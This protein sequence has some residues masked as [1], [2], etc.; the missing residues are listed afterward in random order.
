MCGTTREVELAPLVL[1]GDPLDAIGG[2]ALVGYARV[3]TDGQHL[4]R[5]L[6]ALDAVRCGRVFVEKQS[7]KNADRPALA[8]CLDYLRPGDTLVVLN[9]GRLGRN[10]QDLLTLVAGLRRRGIGFRSLHESL[11]T[12]PVAAWCSTCSPRSR[13]SSAS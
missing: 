2:G 3:S 4:H 9:L 5:Q 6:D 8:A 11:D 10:L 1:D 7:G 12:L 13:S